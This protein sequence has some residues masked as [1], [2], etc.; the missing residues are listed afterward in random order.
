MAN[1]QNHQALD[2]N[3]RISN[4]EA[5]IKKN[6]KKIIAT[7]TAVVLLAGGIFAFFT[8][9]SNR[10]EKGQ[11]QISLGVDQLIQGADSASL[12]KA[13]VGEGEFK[14]FVKLSD[15]YSH[16]DA[17]NL[18][19][20]YAGE[21]YV[22]LGKYK[23]AIAELEKFDAEDDAIASPKIV[24]LLAKC[25]EYDKQFDKAVEAYKD[26]ADLAKNE[27]ISPDCLYCA[28]LILKDQKKN[29]EAKALLEQIKKEY[30]TASICIPKQV[31]PGVYNTPEIDAI[32]ENF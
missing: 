9:K 26:A 15:S 3:A 22:Q 27:A 2:V 18:A 11:D 10:N 17:A 13:L 19:H 23:E 5:F 21:C 6:K 8:W 4:S 30:P 20:A 24:M 12:N 31:A 32:L 14:G 1:K 16:T 29:D 25:Y 28:A 7:A